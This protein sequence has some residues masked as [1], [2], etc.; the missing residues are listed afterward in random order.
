MD[1]YKIYWRNFNNFSESDWTSCAV[2]FSG[3]YGVWGSAAG[4]D[5]EGKKVRLTAH[6]LRDYLRAPESWAAL[7]FLDDKLIGYALSQRLHVRDKGFVTW[8]T[9]FVVHSGHRQKGLGTRLLRAIWSQSNQYAWGLV[10][11]NPFAVRALEKA[12]LRYCDPTRI[13]NSWPQLHEICDPYLKYVKQAADI[14]KSTTTALDTK[15][16]LDHSGTYESLEILNKNGY[17]WLLGDIGDSE[18]WVA[19]TFGDQD[20]S[21]DALSHVQD[22]IIDCDHTVRDAYNGMS[23]D[24]SHTWVKNTVH[25]IDVFLSKVSPKSGAHVVDF[26]CG[27]GRHSIELAKR[28]YNATGIDFVERLVNSAEEIAEYSC[29]T[30]RVNFLLGDVREYEI[31]KQFDHK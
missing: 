24:S 16:P 6:N 7:A 22:W 20:F 14:L 21:K 27:A 8:V 23:L 25:E 13:R 3:H 4:P 15:F 28:G 17:K 31:D 26:G 29:V 1:N 11:A 10:T 2:L 18:E 12:T 9:Q 19:F 5:V 30:P